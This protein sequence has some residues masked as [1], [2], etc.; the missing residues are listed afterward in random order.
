MLWSYK[1]L[2]NLNVN[3]SEDW[4]LIENHIERHLDRVYNI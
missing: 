2:D 1:D 4:K 3:Y